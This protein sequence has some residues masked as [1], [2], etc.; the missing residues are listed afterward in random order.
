MKNLLSEIHL[1]FFQSRDKMPNISVG[2]INTSTE[3]VV[4]PYSEI[5][6]KSR[7][8]SVLLYNAYLQRCCWYVYQDYVCSKAPEAF[9]E[10]KSFENNELN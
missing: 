1:F 2:F 9:V 3:S 8:L 10:T 7:I 5:E 4:P 6:R